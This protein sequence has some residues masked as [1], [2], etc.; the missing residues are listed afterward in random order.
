MPACQQADQVAVDHVDVDPN[1]I[2]ARR[3][4]EIGEHL[5]GDRQPTTGRRSDLLEDE[6]VGELPGGR[7]LVAGPECG[8]VLVGHALADDLA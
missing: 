8:L 6:R 4:H 2:D 7:D 5:E 1:P 3:V